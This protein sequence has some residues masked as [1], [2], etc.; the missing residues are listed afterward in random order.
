MSGVGM[1]DEQ[2][3]CCGDLLQHVS[4]KAS[5]AF[6]YEVILDLA[7]IFRGLWG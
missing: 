3:E 2:P 5:T 4:G 7:K 1:V 6:G